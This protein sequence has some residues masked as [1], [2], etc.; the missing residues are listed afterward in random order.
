VAV[1]IFGV[2]GPFTKRLISGLI[3]IWPNISLT[4]PITRQILGS[5]DFLKNLQKTFFG[6]FSDAGKKPTKNLKKTLRRPQ[7][8]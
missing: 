1:A 5:Q 7:K 8:F 2:A 6:T 3:Y 4:V